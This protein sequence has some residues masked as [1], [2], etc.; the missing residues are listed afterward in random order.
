MYV[1]LRLALSLTTKPTGQCICNQTGNI[2]II[3]LT[4][5]IPRKQ[6][7]MYHLHTCHILV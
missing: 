4:E 3:A 7:S 2:C 1:Y 5:S 6:K